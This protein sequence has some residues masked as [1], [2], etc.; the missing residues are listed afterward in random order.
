MQ[1]HFVQ[2]AHGSVI[3]RIR[4]VPATYLIPSKV[5]V[6][7]LVGIITVLLTISG[8]IELNPGPVKFPWGKRGKAVAKHHKGICCDQCN[9]WLHIRCA[10]I[11]NNEYV[12]LTCSSESWICN[13]CYRLQ[14]RQQQERQQQQTRMQLHQYESERVHVRFPCG[15]CGRPVAT[16]HKGV[17]CDH[18]NKWP[19]IR[20]MCSNDEYV[21]LT[22]SSESWVCSTCYRLENRQQQ[23][24]QQQIRLQLQVAEPEREQLPHRSRHGNSQSTSESSSH[25]SQD[26]YLNSQGWQTESLH[27]QSWAQKHMKQFQVKQTQWQHRKCTIC[28]EQWPTCTRLNIEPF[29]CN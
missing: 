4:V 19:H 29:V 1:V 18:C 26:Q 14:S 3:Q 16:N 13:A 15:E 20:Y 2:T 17:C 12:R 23:Q 9:M 22:H 10:S 25:M 24:T 5:R 8:D 6:R 28:N 21:R 27:K 11:S 7:Q